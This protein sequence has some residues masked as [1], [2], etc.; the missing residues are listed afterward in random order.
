MA[1]IDHDM[2]ALHISGVVKFF[3]LVSLVT[4]TKVISY[5][6]RISVAK[7]NSEVIAHYLSICFQIG[8]LASVLK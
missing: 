7:I 1:G 5:C 8:L 3:L 2:Q 4:A 6:S